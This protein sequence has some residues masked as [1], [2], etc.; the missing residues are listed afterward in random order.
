[1]VSEDHVKNDKTPI[2]IFL[3]MCNLRK[4]IICTQ[5]REI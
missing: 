4:E 3:K 2:V 5:I 1:M